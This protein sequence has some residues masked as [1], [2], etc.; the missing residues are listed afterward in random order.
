MKTNS[1]QYCIICGE[2][3]AKMLIRDLHFGGQGI[4]KKCEN[5]TEAKEEL[6]LE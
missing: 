4:C 1:K 2:M 3:K 5:T 6:G